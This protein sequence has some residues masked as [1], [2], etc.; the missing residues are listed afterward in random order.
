M[1]Q[2]DTPGYGERIAYVL[3]LRA[4]GRMEPETDAEVATGAGVGYVW[5]Q[6]WKRRADAPA[7][8]TLTRLLCRYLNPEGLAAFDDWLLDAVGSPPES[9]LW[10]IWWGRRLE[11]R[12]AEKRPA[13]IAPI[14]PRANPRGSA[15]KPAQKKRRAG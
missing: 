8:R 2:S 1:S 5:F 11:L 12:G 4:R 10:G 7:D 15:G 13:P 14:I 6:K 9:G 3:W